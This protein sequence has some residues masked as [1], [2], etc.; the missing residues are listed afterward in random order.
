M[1][2]MTNQEA[3][4]EKPENLCFIS[5]LLSDSYVAWQAYNKLRQTACK[6]LRR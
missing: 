3:R 5:K 2:L 4:I 1:Q 6:S